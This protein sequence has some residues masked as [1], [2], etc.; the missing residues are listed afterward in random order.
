MLPSPT[1]ELQHL[2]P[3]CVA[4]KLSSSWFGFGGL[5]WGLIGGLLGRLFWVLFGGL[6][7]EV[8]KV[9]IGSDLLSFGELFG[10]LFLE[11]R[12][13]EVLCWASS[14]STSRSTSITTELS[15]TGP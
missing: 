7:W 8:L 5:F 12:G 2:N 10:G 11:E 9:S 13:S 3:N 14:R 6:F 15:W 1:D 4:V